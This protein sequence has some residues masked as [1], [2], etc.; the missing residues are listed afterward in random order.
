MGEY[1]AGCASEH[2]GYISEFN[3]SKEGCKT[4]CLYQVC[5]ERMYT[6]IGLLIGKYPVRGMSALIN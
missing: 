2:C 1:V 3:S 4:D 6:K 5:I